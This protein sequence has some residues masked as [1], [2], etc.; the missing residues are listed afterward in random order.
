MPFPYE[1]ESPVEVLPRAT[2]GVGGEMNG[3]M[4][5]HPDSY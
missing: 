1:R 4:R 3:E 2:S 5:E